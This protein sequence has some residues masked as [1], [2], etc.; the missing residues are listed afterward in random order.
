MRLA[1]TISANDSVLFLDELPE[2]RG[3]RSRRLVLRPRE[4][5]VFD[6]GFV[7]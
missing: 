2:F 1:P 3:R 4:R 5:V 6:H 7:A